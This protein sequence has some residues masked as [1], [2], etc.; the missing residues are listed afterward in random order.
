MIERLQE[1]MLY[2]DDQENAKQFWT[3]KL[4]FKVI[5]DDVANDM[6]VII[7]SPTTDAQ[8]SIVL[9]DKAKGVTVGDKVDMPGGTIFNFSDDEGH[10]FAVRS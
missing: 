6:R 8:T 4:N 1:V 3:E 5:S 7:L 10:Y 2:V 9:H